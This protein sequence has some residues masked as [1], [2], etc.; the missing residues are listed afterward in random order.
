MNQLAMRYRGHHGHC[1]QSRHQGLMWGGL[2]VLAGVLFLLEGMGHLGG[3]RTWQFWPLILVVNGVFDVFRPH[4]GHRMWG[5]LLTGIGALLLVHFLGLAVIPWSLI[6]PI[7][8]VILGIYVTWVVIAI[9]RHPLPTSVSPGSVNSTVV[10]GEQTDRYDNDDFEGGQVRTT[11]GSYELDLRGAAM[12]GPEAH[13]VVRVT[14]G[15]VKLRVPGEWQVV[16]K[17][18]PVLGNIEDRSGS[19]PKNP[20]GRSVLVV[21]ASV[22]LGELRITR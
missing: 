3:Y 12:K 19:T 1:K 17:G 15:E 13:L 21:H 7:G 22:V 18:Y 8:L 11:M 10:M 2:I 16:V 20:A 14:M 6:W 9:G 5:V 4:F